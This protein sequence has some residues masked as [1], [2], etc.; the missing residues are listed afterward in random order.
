MQIGDIVRSMQ[1]RDAGHIYL[2]VGITTERVL[3]ADGVTRTVKQPKLKNPKHLT[4]FGAAPQ[5]TLERLTAGHHLSNDEIR[6][7]IGTYVQQEGGDPDAK[8]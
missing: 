3:V 1:G 4:P 8:R 6:Q 2:I 7:L 5:E